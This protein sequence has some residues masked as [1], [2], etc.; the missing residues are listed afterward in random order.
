MKQ[1][2]EEQK[3]RSQLVLWRR[4]L[5]TLQ[6]FLLEL[7]TDASG[8]SSVRSAKFKVGHTETNEWS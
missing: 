7:L 4:P 6:Y 2:I 5:T 3:E 1:I 8:A